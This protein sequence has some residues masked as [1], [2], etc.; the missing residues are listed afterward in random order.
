MTPRRPPAGS[1]P[2]TKARLREPDGAAGGD[3]VWPP[4]ADDPAGCSI[5]LIGTEAGHGPRPQTTVLAEE[6]AEAFPD[7]EAALDQ[8][9]DSPVAPRVPLTARPARPRPPQAAQPPASRWRAAALRS[10]VGL[11]IG[12]S[13]ALMPPPGLT[14][15]LDARPLAVPATTE[16]LRVATPPRIG[17][18]NRARVAPTPVTVPRPGK[19]VLRDE[20]RIRTTLA[21]LRA[22]YSRL[23]AGAAR[24][25]WPSVDVDA[26]TRA[27]DGLEWQELRFDHC[28]VTVDGARARAACTGEALYVPRVG[29]AGSSAARAWTFELRR[30]GERWMIA[31]ARAS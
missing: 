12:A 20:D 9:A 29:S 31:S 22:A 27:F 13:L 2:S 4:P 24:E 3:F 15:V 6:P 14:R 30:R 28:D 21:A 17:T 8:F 18:L 1:S 10:V 26:L 25:V 11:G 5:V 19:V 7:I 16:P 23:D